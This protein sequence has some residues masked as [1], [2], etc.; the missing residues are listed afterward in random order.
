[1]A[2]LHKY[3]N[4]FEFLCHVL[5]NISRQ[6]QWVQTI[7]INNKIFRD[8]IRWL[9]NFHWSW[10]H[11]H[12]T[13]RSKVMSNH[14]CVK[15]QYIRLDFVSFSAFSVFYISSV[16]NRMTYLRQ[17]CTTN[18]KPPW[19]KPNVMK[20]K[21]FMWRPSIFS[22]T[23]NKNGKVRHKCSL[24]ISH[25]HQLPFTVETIFSS[26]YWCDNKLLMSHIHTFQVIGLLGQLESKITHMF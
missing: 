16:S 5:A 3:Y 21:N 11:S 26:Q 24:N 19:V 25:A 17:L 22:K 2:F 4:L 14:S 18:A 12:W 1:M 10:S 15:G 23:Y 6:C 9:H 13:L 7:F 20:K 8:L